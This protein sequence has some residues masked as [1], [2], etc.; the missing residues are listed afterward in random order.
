MNKSQSAKEIPIDSNYNARIWNHNGG[1]VDVLPTMVEM[2][3][4]VS[5]YANYGL[6]VNGLPPHMYVMVDGKMHMQLIKLPVHVIV[7][8][9]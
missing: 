1:K 4:D 9:S 6:D 7:I 3:Y 8:P 2:D 5:L